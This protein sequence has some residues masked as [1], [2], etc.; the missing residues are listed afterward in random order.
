MYSKIHKAVL[1][2]TEHQTS[3]KNLN[4]RWLKLAEVPAFHCGLESDSLMN[5]S[6]LMT[7][8]DLFQALLCF[9]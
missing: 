6:M 8:G 9:E 4:S 5:L 2:Y 1:R 7:L 3:A